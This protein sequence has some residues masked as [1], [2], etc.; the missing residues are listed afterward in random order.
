MILHILK[1]ML[2]INVCYMVGLNVPAT[3]HQC[4]LYMTYY[5]RTY[6]LLTVNVYYI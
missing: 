1:D 4:A 2:K 5:G 3:D 6:Q